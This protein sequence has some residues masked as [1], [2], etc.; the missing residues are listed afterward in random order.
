MRIIGALLQRPR[1]NRVSTRHCFEF[2]R[3]LKNIDRNF[4]NLVLR[5]VEFSLQFFSDFC[6]KEE[7]KECIAAMLVLM[8]LRTFRHLPVEAF[9]ERKIADSM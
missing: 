3:D 1:L 9:W 6:S 4:P 7:L 2:L 8:C 5:I